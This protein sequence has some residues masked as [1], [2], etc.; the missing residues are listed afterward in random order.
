MVKNNNNNNNNDDDDE[1]HRSVMDPRGPCFRHGI[2]DPLKRLCHGN[3]CHE[4]TPN[5]PALTMCNPNATE[6]KD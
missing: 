3:Y 5:D 4:I 6:A 2:V 1:G